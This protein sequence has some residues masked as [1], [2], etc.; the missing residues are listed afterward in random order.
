VW[1][2]DAPSPV[3]QIRPG[4]A[5]VLDGHF[6]VARGRDIRVQ[7][8]G[9]RGTLDLQPIDADGGVLVTIPSH[10]SPGEWQLVVATRDGSAPAR[11][12]TTIHVK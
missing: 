3:P 8:K 12:V 9:L 4:E 7:L 11:N 6:P 1:T 10:A 5:L 2:K